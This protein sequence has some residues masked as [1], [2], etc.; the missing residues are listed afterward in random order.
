MQ[1]FVDMGDIMAG[2][3]KSLSF[4]IIVTWVCTYKGFYVGHG[5]EGVA[6]PRP[7]PSCCPRC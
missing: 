6:G 7:R 3:W 4:G 5:A 1:T 2:F